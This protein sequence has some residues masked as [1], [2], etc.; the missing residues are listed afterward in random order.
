MTVPVETPPRTVASVTT[1]VTATVRVLDTS[2]SRAQ[3]MATVSVVV[4]RLA[5]L[6]VEARSDAE[7][8]KS[9]WMS[10]STVGSVAPLLSLAPWGLR[11][12]TRAP[13]RPVSAPRAVMSTP[14]SSSNS[15][16]RGSPG[17]SLCRD[18]SGRWAATLNRGRGSDSVGVLSTLTTMVRARGREGGRNAPQPLVF[19][20]WRSFLVAYI[21]IYQPTKVQVFL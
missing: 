4:W 9:V 19:S 21:I 18:K 20:L 5:L 8:G 7:S 12:R 3:V 14:N 15:R 10:V 1:R 13:T 11:A 6:L 17:S 16:R 2:S